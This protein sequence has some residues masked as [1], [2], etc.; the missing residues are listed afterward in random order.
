[1]YM[2]YIYVYIP[3]GAVIPQGDSVAEEE[4]MMNERSV[5]LVINCRISE[6]LS[7]YIYVYMMYIYVYI[8]Q[9]AVMPQGDNV[10]E[11]EA[12]VNERSVR[13]S[14]VI[15]SRIS[16]S[17]YVYICMCV[18]MY[19]YVYMYICKYICLYIYINI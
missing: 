8:P 19:I 12:M 17:I 13:H 14:P 4:A 18:Y 10:A 5:R 9:G 6:S 16:K 15:D 11:E 2:M 1:M 7:I 3:Q